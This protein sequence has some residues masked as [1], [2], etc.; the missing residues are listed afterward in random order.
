MA[1]AR[2]N[3]EVRAERWV[4]MVAAVA[5]AMVPTMRSDGAE[6]GEFCESCVLGDCASCAPLCSVSAVVAAIGRA[7]G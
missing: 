6:L 3:D 1:S 7:M 4:G 2:E 5:A